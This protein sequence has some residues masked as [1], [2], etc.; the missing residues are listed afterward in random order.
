MRNALF[1][2]VIVSVCLFPAQG[3]MTAACRT[4][5]GRMGTCG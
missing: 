1:C 4:V 3:V 2:V 5:V